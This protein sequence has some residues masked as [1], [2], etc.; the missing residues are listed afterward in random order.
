MPKRSHLDTLLR[1]LFIAVLL[2]VV[3]IAGANP[4]AEVRSQY[5]I[6][7]K[8]LLE[9]KV[10]EVPELNIERRVEEGGAVR[11]P[12][13]GDF[14][15]SGLTVNEIADKLRELLESR[16]I[17]RASVSVEVREIR[18]RPIAVIGAVRQ[19]GN[20]AVSGR[21]TLLE[22]IAAAGG[23]NERHGNAIHVIRRAENGLADQI[24]IDIETLMVEAD[25]D[26]NIPVFAGDVINVPAT[27]EITLFCL[28]EVRQPGALTFKNTERI[29][30]LAAIA[31]AGGLTDRASK[32]I[33]IRRRDRTGAETEIEVSY[34]QIVNGKAPDVELERDDVVVVKESFF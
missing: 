21:W 17:Q 32:T 4:Q 18:S 34:K 11:L 7:P 1:S 12:L 5:R 15:V 19:P 16:Y 6:G 9:I 27:V 10:F 29:T 13:I 14:H 25:P 20:L 26:V 3:A 28:G 23:L 2:S 24:R 31:R 33:V 8:D 30:L 22:A